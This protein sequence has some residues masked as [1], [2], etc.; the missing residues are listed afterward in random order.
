MVSGRNRFPGLKDRENLGYGEAT[1]HDTMRLGTVV[2]LG[3]PHST[4]CDTQVGEYKYNVLDKHNHG[5]HIYLYS[6][7]LAWSVDFL[8]LNELGH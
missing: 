5:D 1:L 6:I 8:G 4:L 7:Y 2:P 3:V